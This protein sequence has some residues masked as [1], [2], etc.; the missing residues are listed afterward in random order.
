MEDK[1]NKKFRK[2]KSL[3]DLQST[4]IMKPGVTEYICV[5]NKYICNAYIHTLY[6]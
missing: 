5:Q 3:D 4:G 1:L 6:I 2:R